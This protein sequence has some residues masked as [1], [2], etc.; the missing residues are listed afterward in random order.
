MSL[1]KRVDYTEDYKVSNNLRT[2][3]ID[4][5]NNAKSGH[6]GICLGASDIIYTLYAYHLKIISRILSFSIY[7]STHKYINIY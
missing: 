1:L 6:P 4:M 7:R 5:I 3:S 2:L